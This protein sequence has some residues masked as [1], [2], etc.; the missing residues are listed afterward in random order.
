[1]HYVCADIHGNKERY[2][3]MINVI[4]PDDTLY[5]L[6]DVIDRGPSGIDII[7]DIMTRENVVLLVGNHEDMMLQSLLYDRETEHLNWVQLCNG[8]GITEYAFNQEPF[9]TQEEILHYLE[10]RNISIKIECNG[11][12]Y[13]LCHSGT[14]SGK[15]D[16]LY[17]D[18]SK[19]D[20]YMI[21]WMSP[22]RIDYKAPLEIYDP[23]YHYI[24]GH[25][26]V[27][28]VG[29]TTI[30]TIPEAKY[31]VPERRITDIDCGCSISDFFHG[32]GYTSLA[33]L[34][35]EDFYCRYF[36]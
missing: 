17:K 1:M 23:A 8:G 25:V 19:Q 22:L 21:L 6:G 24:I 20:K 18:A 29:S 36:V 32:P 31:S 16:L 9:Q 34:C 7:K 2:D 12:T 27:Q 30:L 14:I 5:I 10:S 13:V 26:P 4:K 35:L 28:R 15:E 11:T 33:L 3:K